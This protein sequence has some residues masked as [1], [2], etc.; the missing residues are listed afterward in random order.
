MKTGEQEVRLEGFWSGFR[1]SELQRR[2]PLWEHSRD[3][4]IPGVDD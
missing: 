1:A 3:Q 2:N 4:V